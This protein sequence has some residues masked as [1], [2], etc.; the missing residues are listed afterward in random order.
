MPV[1]QK[2]LSDDEFNESS[3]CISGIVDRIKSAVQ[4]P[5]RLPYGKRNKSFEEYFSRF[6]DDTI[7][8]FIAKLSQSKWVRNPTFT[9]DLIVRDDLVNTLGAGP[10]ASLKY[11]NIET[12]NLSKFK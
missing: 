12:L 10:C 3:S 1:L 4:M 5:I 11:Y 6:D 2:I 7:D 9:L 8:R